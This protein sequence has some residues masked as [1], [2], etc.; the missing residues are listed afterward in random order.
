MLPDGSRVV[1]APQ[2]T[3]QVPN[4]FGNTSRTVSVVGEVHFDVAATS[5][6][7]FVVQSGAVTTRV[8]GTT[9]DVRRYRGEQIGRVVVYRGKVTTGSRGPTVTLTAGMEAPV[10]DSGVVATT[11][12]SNSEVVDWTRGELVFHR[13]PVTVLLGALQRWYGY[14]FRL[15]DTT[16]AHRP[17]T[18]T[19]TIGETAD[20][21]QVVQRLLGVRMTFQDS[22]VILR[23]ATGARGTA[24]DER[25][26]TRD[27]MHTPLT[28]TREIGR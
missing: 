21:L 5:R 3:L 24:N 4:D 10:S 22:V 8:L 9:F 2:T 18:A 13:V 23:P 15:M 1:L 14:E 27:R 16:L 17:V 25:T 7:P 20:M 11:T 19:F 26:T 12:T 6:A 28:Y